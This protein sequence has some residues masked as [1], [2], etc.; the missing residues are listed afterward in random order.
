MAFT[1]IVNSD[2]VTISIPSGLGGGSLVAGASTTVAFDIQTVGA[3][4]SAAGIIHYGMSSV[5]AG[6]ASGSISSNPG[7]SYSN[8]LRPAAS[9]FS[10]GAAV[11]NTDDNAYN[12]SDGTNWRDAAGNI[13]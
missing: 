8:V 13:T 12:Y 2:V 5:D 9:A 11:W 10:I 4:M 1:K 7:A 3:A 6:G